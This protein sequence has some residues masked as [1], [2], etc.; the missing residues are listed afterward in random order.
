[1]NTHR[2]LQRF[3]EFEQK[4][5]Y[6][7]AGA[8][9]SRRQGAASQPVAT[10]EYDLSVSTAAVAPA[11][12]G[13]GAAG[14]V[15][16]GEAPNTPS[17]SAGSYFADLE[18]APGSGSSSGSGR[19]AKPQVWSSLTVSL[20]FSKQRSTFCCGALAFAQMPTCQLQNCGAGVS[21]ACCGAGPEV[22]TTVPSRRPQ[23]RQ[24]AG[25]CH[26]HTQSQ[27]AAAAAWRGHGICAAGRTRQL[28][29]GP[30][31]TRRQAAA[32]GAGRRQ[33]SCRA[34]AATAAV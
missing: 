21:L 13:N 1:M 29:H 5:L 19:S 22:G 34:A 9:G 33:C 30:A 15:A 31:G 32:A 23:P 20:A 26:R 7:C 14:C 25:G 16:R 11:L 12:D 18:S 2:W 6:G 8:S 3:P 17:T 24:A 10:V 4:L 27:Q 28:R